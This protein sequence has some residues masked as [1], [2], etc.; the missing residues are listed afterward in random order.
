MRRVMNQALLNLNLAGQGAVSKDKDKHSTF[1]R[2]SEQA[3]T[4]RICFHLLSF[5]LCRLVTLARSRLCRTL[6][7][8][9]SHTPLPAPTHT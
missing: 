1:Y 9:L 6:S 8:S 3:L 2:L 4:L 7:L 5:A